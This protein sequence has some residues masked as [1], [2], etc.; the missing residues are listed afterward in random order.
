MPPIKCSGVRIITIAIVY[1]TIYNIQCMINYI[2]NNQNDSNGSNNS[3][4][5]HDHDNNN[6]NDRSTN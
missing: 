5:N 1:D 6:D 2:D 3:H 4:G